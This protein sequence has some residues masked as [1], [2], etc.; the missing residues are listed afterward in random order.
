MYLAADAPAEVATVDLTPRRCQEFRPR[1]GDRLRWRRYLV[2]GQENLDSGELLAD[3]WGLVTIGELQ[4][5]K[6]KQRV[7]IVCVSP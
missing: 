7:E 1:N 4:L 6:E 2:G 3:Q 5:L